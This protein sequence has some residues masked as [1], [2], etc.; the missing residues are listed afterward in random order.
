M[1]VLLVLGVLTALLVLYAADRV[2]KAR[3]RGRRLRRMSERLAAAAARAER[4][5]AQKEAAAQ[6][7][8]ALT[9][10]IPAINHRPPVTLPGHPARENESAS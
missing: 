10:V 2:L 9:S 1:S 6:A 7:S 3:V 8:A 4:Q 5:Q